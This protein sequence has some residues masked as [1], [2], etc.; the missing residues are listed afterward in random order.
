MRAIGS[1]KPKG[2]MKVKS[3]IRVFIS[4]A[5]EPG[6]FIYGQVRGKVC[7]PRPER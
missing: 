6:M 5:T 7:I 1:F 4:C 3:V 2:E